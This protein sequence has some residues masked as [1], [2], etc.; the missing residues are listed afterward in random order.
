M[1]VVKQE[2]K[3]EIKPVVKQEISENVSKNE[4]ERTEVGSPDISIELDDEKDDYGKLL[5]M[6]STLSITRYEVYIFII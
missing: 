1:P 6:L 3:Q 4:V 5:Y 2:L